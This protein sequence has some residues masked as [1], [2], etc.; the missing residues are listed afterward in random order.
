V[1]HQKIDAI[2]KDKAEKL[3]D[4]DKYKSFFFAIKQI[5]E[6]K[7]RKNSVPLQMK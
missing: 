5:T 7:N 3:I 6:K 4:M 1:S 2:I